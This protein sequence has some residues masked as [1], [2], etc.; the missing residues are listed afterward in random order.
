LKRRTLISGIG[1]VALT[2]AVSR[3][4]AAWIPANIGNGFAALDDNFNL[5]PLSGADDPG[6]AGVPAG[7]EGMIEANAFRL[8]L[9]PFLRSGAQTHQFCS[10]DRAGDNYD[11]EYLALYT[12]KNGECVIFDAMGPGCLS[13]HQ[14][15]IWHDHQIYKGIVIRYYFDDE[16]TPRIDMD[17]STFFS[18]EN[19]L[20]IFQPSLAWDGKENFRVFYHPMYFR[21]RLKISFSAEPGGPGTAP[22]PWLGRYSDLPNRRNH[23][24]NYTY[25]LFSRDQGLDSW[26]PETARRMMPALSHAVSA[27]GLGSGTKPGRGIR[28][29]TAVRA[30]KAGKT[31]T[32]WKKS[33][34]A[35]SIASLRLNIDPASNEDALFNTWLKITF[36]GA[37]SPQIET[38]LGCFFG[39]YRTSLA[40]SYAA[41]P[42]GYASGEGYCAFP[43]PFWT[44]AVIQADNRS[45]TEVTL[46]AT[47]E[48]RDAAAMTYARERCGYLHAHYHREDP[49][50]EGKDYTYLETSGHGQIVG[51][52]VSRWDTSMEEDERTYFDGSRTPWIY[53]EGFEDDHDMG[54][55]LKNVTQ[56]LFGAIHAD[57]GSGGVYR[58]L[59]PDMYCFSSGIKY[60]HQTY[61]PHSPLGHEG[62]YQVGAEESVAFWYGKPDAQLI[63]TDE[64]DVGN[65]ESEVAHAYRATGDVEQ[66]RG[67]YWY[68]GEFNNVL[69]KTPAIVDDGA[70]FIGSSTFTVAISPDNRGVR[71]RRRCDKAN[72]RQ[73]AMV[74]IDGQMVT[75]RPWYSVDYEKTYR[76]IRW[77][78][79]D[80]EVP[81]KYARGKNKITVRIEFV[82]SKTGRWDEYRYWVFSYG[83]PSLTE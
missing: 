41:L 49:R 58:F 31:A 1:L 60:G 69:F 4:R 48:T 62:M 32:L 66:V 7:D 34:R 67:A 44:S 6:A 18:N 79:S 47:V 51:H 81:E 17:V 19:P 59:L 12:E 70:S 74:F 72:N 11:A 15:N 54:W 43:M 33:G 61:G 28:Q 25:Q 38:P 52:V 30:V 68:D 77:F 27:N 13:R 21:K 5:G 35:G 40:S 57:G 10:Y 65:A 45:K 83:A 37:S 53:G 56:P 75:E 50:T 46:T 80:F 39:A 78:D 8:D 3:A 64:L 20:G 36:D 29:H 42:L 26:T 55:G 24:Y 2:E 16:T 76:D 73:R 9:L 82:S 22:M 71:L 14:M 23:W 63:Q